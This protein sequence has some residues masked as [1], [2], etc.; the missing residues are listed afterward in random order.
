MRQVARFPVLA[1]LL[2]GCGNNP[3]FGILGPSGGGNGAASSTPSTIGF[4]AVY[5][6]A[7]VSPTP[8]VPAAGIA[9]KSVIGQCVDIRGDGTMIQSIVYTQDNPAQI[10]R[11][12]DTWTYTLSASNIV[13]KDP[14]AGAA[15]TAAD[16]R[17]VRRV[18]MGEAP[19]GKLKIRSTKYEREFTLVRL[20]RVFAIWRPEYSS[21]R[22]IPESA[23]TARSQ[24]LVCCL[25]RAGATKTG[26]P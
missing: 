7:S 16:W 18:N 15:A 9:Q 14:L 22:T 4:T 12:T 3:L 25:Y 10:T 5:I 21:T 8:F 20:P 24:S 26:F 6:L 11:E 1:A 17:K 2:C 19:G 13:T 23:Q